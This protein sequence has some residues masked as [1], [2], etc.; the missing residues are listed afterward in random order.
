MIGSIYGEGLYSADLYSWET[1]WEGKPCD[2][3][4]RP[5]MYVPPSSVSWPAIS[6]APVMRHV[7]FVPPAANW[8]PVGCQ[9]LTER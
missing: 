6:C 3:I 5:P 4:S 2:P 8:Q 7:A 1:A 9:P